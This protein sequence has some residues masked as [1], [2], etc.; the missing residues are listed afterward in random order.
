MNV[1]DLFAQAALCYP[2]KKALIF[3]SGSYTYSE[4]HGIIGALARYLTDIGVSE[5]DRVSIYMANRPEWIMFYY[6]IAKIGAIGVCVPGA[7]KTEEMKGVVND[8]L[9]CAIITSEA[10]LAQFPPPDAIPHIRRVIV[11]ERDEI[12]QSVLRG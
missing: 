6:A 4:M 9:S 7:Y 5:G 10:L 1:A 11:V 8:S 3:G 2:D 12:L